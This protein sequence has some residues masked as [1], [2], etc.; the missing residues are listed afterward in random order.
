M[1]WYLQFCTIGGEMR[2]HRGTVPPLERAILA[3]MGIALHGKNE[4]LHGHCIERMR[5]CMG[6]AW[7]E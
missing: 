3:M 1:N 4:A 5:Q 6:I 2:V 7:K